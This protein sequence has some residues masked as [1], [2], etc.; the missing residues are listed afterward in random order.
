MI[1]NDNNENFLTTQVRKLKSKSFSDYM[2]ITIITMVG[3]LIVAIMCT[4]FVEFVL[5]G[6]INWAEISANTVFISA[7]T[8]AIYLLLRSYSIR[9]GRKSAE[10]L[11]SSERLKS[12]AKSVIDK[13][14]A[15]HISEYCG[16]WEDE[17]LDNDLKDTLSSVGITVTD[18]KEKY[19]KFSNKELKEQ[20]TDLTAYQLKTILQAKKIK[21]LKFDERYFYSGVRGGR[22]R[23]SPSSELTTRQLNRLVN[24]RIIITTVLTL[25][26]STTLLWDVILNFSWEALI[27]CVVKLAIIIFYGVLG[28]MGGYTFATVNEVD[29]MNSKSDEIEVFIKWC[30]KE[31]ANSRKTD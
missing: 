10:W 5:G 31:K 24:M 8:I 29:E 9:K 15:K 11:Q 18:F 17:R 27:K 23:R 16:A 22:R 26:L 28:M 19:L 1:Q 30:E 25:L 12:L 6:K 4:F 13:D 14:M 2:D 20:C 21:R 3:I 7:C